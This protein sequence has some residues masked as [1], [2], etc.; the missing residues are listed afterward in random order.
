MKDLKQFIKTTLKDYL[1]ESKHIGVIYHF[2]HLMNLYSILENK[3][4][5]SRYNDLSKYN[6]DYSVSCTRNQSFKW[7]G[8]RIML[9][10]DKISNSFVVKP[11]S[12]FKFNKSQSE[13]RIFTNK[14]TFPIFDYIIQIDILEHL[15]DDDMF[16]D[17][18]K[19]LNESNI[20]YNLVSNF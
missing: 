1:V 13:E 8:I 4:F 10:G 3:T 9:D 18:L 20:K 7:G 6:Y 11:V 14:E 5:M 15:K 2:T 12:Y 16:D 17:V 19:L